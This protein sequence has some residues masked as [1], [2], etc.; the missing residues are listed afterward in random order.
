MSERVILSGGPGYVAAGERSR[1]VE[2]LADEVKLS[3]Y[4]GHE[5]FSFT[6][7]YEIVDGDRAA[8]MRWCG[9]TAVA[10]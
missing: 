2:D 4:G 5:H 8:V 1:V 9:R 10:E 6:G 3:C 7:E